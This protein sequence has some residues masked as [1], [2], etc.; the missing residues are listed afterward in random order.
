MP[1]LGMFSIGLKNVNS[2]KKHEFAINLAKEE[3]QHLRMKEDALDLAGKDAMHKRKVKGVG[4]RQWVVV[5]RTVPH[6]EPLEI[7]IE[8]FSNAQP[9]PVFDLVTYIMNHHATGATQ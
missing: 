5:R 2:A 8:V 6:T 7:R 9:K 3:L 1:M 4:G